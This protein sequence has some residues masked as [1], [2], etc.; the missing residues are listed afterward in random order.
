MHLSQ[1]MRHLLVLLC[2][3][4][5]GSQGSSSR[6]DLLDV[7]AA[8]PQAVGLASAHSFAVPHSTWG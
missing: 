2:L 5:T 8:V 3:L 7:A 1:G 6:G 4:V